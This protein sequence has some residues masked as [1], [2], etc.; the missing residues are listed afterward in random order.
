[1]IS[2]LCWIPKGVA[3]EE[4]IQAELTEEELAALKAAAGGEGPEEVRW[5][6]TGGVG[7][8]GGVGHDG[9]RARLGARGCGYGYSVR[10]QTVG[11]EQR[12]PRDGGHNTRRSRPAG[13]SRGGQ[14]RPAPK[15][16]HFAAYR[17]LPLGFSACALPARKAPACSLTIVTSTTVNR[18]PQQEEEE[19][20]S[21]PSNG[22]LDSLHSHSKPSTPP[23]CR[24]RRNRIPSPAA[25]HSTLIID[26]ANPPPHCIAGGGGVG[27]RAQRQR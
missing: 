26:I 27:F 8:P 19:S 23:H 22:L 6:P 21:E 9:M 5:W 17:T 16:F 12:R 24:R 4:P 11:V 15:P 7:Q 25:A 2:S 14:G 10:G 20:D 18:P 3:K 13:R 1:M